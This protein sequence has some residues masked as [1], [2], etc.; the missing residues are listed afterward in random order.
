MTNRRLDRLSGIV[1]VIL[2]VF[3]M[4]GSWAM[5]RFEAQDVPV[6][7]APGLTPG[8]LGLGLALSGLILAVRTGRSDAGETHYWDQVTGTPANRK[9]A[10][11]ALALTLLYGGVLFGN[12]PYVLAT[13][14]FVLA[15]VVTFEIL[16]KPADST[17]RTVPSALVALTLALVTSFGSAY[18]FRTLFLVQLP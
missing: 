9:R 18:V 6:Y 8:L 5:P 15:F 3:V 2:G 17:R 13:F 11:A 16:L 10:I 4:L 1:F 7:Q 14:L 12:T